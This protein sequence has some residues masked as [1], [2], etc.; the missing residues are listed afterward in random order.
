[1]KRL[2]QSLV[3]IILAVPAFTGL[4]LTNGPP[5]FL[6]IQAGRLLYWLVTALAIALLRGRFL[7]LAATI[8][9]FVIAIPVAGGGALLSLL[10]YA[11]GLSGMT[12]H[13]IAAH[14]VFLFINMLSMIPLGIALVSLIPTA[15]METYLL[16]SVIGVG[17]VRK[18]LLMGLRV[19]NH[20]VFT[21]MPEILQTVTEEL[22]FNGYVY[23]SGVQIKRRRRLFLRGLLQKFMFVAVAALC[24]SVKYIHFWAAEISA[25]PGKGAKRP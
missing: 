23:K 18:I 4:L 2:L 5:L 25:L 19:F 1:M 8:I 15:A 14:Y 22:R 12:L 11:L 9:A 6:D 24:L 10:L 13:Q 20:V 17:T 3:L 16:R 21:V 7:W